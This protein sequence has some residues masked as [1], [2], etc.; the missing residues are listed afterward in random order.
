MAC[1]LEYIGKHLPDTFT[2]EN[3]KAITYT[4]HR[5]FLNKILT[6]MRRIIDPATGTRA[7]NVEYKI[8]DTKVHGGLPQSR[9]RWYCVGIRRAVQVSGFIWPEPIPC[10]P[11][12]DVTDQKPNPTR[13]AKPKPKT[14][15]DRYL[16]ALQFGINSIVEKNG[17]PIRETWFVD[18][19]A[20]E[21]RTGVYK[22]V[23]HEFAN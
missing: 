15:T 9:Q 8:L 11:Y 2:F 1:G 10:Q 3:V 12:K 21:G 7:Y 13:A 17:D 23:S 22:D 6:A 4:K 19:E 20:T 5:E 14:A 18:P 16:S